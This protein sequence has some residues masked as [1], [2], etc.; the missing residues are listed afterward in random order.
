MENASQSTLTTCSDTPAVLSFATGLLG[1]P[2]FALVA[3]V[4]F[5]GVGEEGVEFEGKLKSSRHGW[6]IA[7]NSDDSAEN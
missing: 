7:M 4:P 5:F 3:L 2:P 1:D 6:A